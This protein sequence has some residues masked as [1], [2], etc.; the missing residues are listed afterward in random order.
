VVYDRKNCKK[1]KI[2]VWEDEEVK[3]TLTTGEVLKFLQDLR[4]F[5]QANGR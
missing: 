5:V 2:E 4:A 3:F 1:N